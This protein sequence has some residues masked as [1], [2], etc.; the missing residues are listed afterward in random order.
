VIYGLDADLIMLCINHLNICPNIYLFRETPEFIKSINS[1]LEP[2]ENYILDIPQLA[3]II[4]LNMNNGTSDNYNNKIYDYIFMCF[5]LGN[6][7]MPHFPSINIRTGGIDKMLNA[8]KA[9]IGDKNEYLTDGNKIYW[10]NVRK[11]VQHLA[12][13]EEEYLKNETK[14]RDKRAKYIIP[15]TTPEE[16]YKKFDLIP[17]YDRSIEKSINPFKHNW[18]NRYYKY[19]FNLEINENHKKEIC[20]NYLEG[21][22]W[23]MKYYT[24]GC[25]NW[26]W[27]YNYNYPP[28]LSDLIH[29]I[30]Y[31]EKDLVIYKTPNP[32]T[33]IVQLSYVLPKQSLHLLPEQIY[34]KLLNER[35]E[36]YKSDCNFIWAYCRYFW[37]SH[38]DLPDI[39]IDELETLLIAN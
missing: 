17:N 1:E 29:H 2:N 36:W 34:N 13:L 10:K 30:P 16:K 31:F 5:F 7:F 25:P 18:Q 11:L 15:D 27:C 24:T 4:T 20:I 19:L 22:E 23:T 8:Y 32:V 14:L 6:D 28:L 21:L 39:N 9:V 12:S 26:R 3:K 37:E 35:S 33:E 38:V